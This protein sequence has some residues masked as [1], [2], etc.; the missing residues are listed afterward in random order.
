MGA[1][2]VSGLLACMDWYIFSDMDGNN[3][4]D[5]IAAGITAQG[6][7]LVCNAMANAGSPSRPPRRCGCG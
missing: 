1:N 4:V 6:G 7:I 2:I 3:A 5:T